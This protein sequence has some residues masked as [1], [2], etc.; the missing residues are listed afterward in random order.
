[1]GEGLLFSRLAVFDN[2][3]LEKSSRRIL[4]FV[5]LGYLVC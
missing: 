2:F 1:M 3:A 4:D 5:V